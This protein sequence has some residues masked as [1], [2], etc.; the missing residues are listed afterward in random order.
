MKIKA[1]SP[2]KYIDQ[3]PADRKE[4][5]KK[6]RSTILEH[7]PEGFEEIMNYGM[8]GYVVP[9]SLYPSGYHVD[10]EQPLPFINIGSQTNHIALYHLGIYANQD[11]L[12]WFT[13]EYSKFSKY[14]LDMGKSCM[15][16]RKTDQIPYGLIAELIARV[17]VEEWVQLYEKAVQKNK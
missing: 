13:S 11:L 4:A 15:R 17:S 9:K 6:L 14:K 10:P 16:F 1:N 3:L 8:I 7:L 2:E 12:N 5:I